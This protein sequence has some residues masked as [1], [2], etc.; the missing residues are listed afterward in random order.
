MIP[1]SSDLAERRN[2]AALETYLEFSFFLH[3]GDV[4]DAVI[5]GSNI[6]VVS[7]LC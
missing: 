7:V 1:S 3:P 2:C 4:A 6:F 5:V